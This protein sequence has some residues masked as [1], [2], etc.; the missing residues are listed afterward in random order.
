MRPIFCTSRSLGRRPS[1]IICHDTLGTRPNCRPQSDKR[2]HP[3]LERSLLI[4][5]SLLKRQQLPTLTKLRHEWNPSEFEDLARE[6]WFL[7]P[8]FRFSSGS[9]GP[10]ESGFEVKL[11]ADDPEAVSRFETQMSRILNLYVSRMV[12]KLLPV[13][14]G[15]P[16][17]RRLV[18]S[19]ELEG[20]GLPPFERTMPVRGEQCLLDGLEFEV[21]LFDLRNRQPYRIP[22]R[23][24][25]EYLARWGGVHIYD[26]GFR[27]PSEPG[28]DW[29][30]L[31]SDQSR[32]LAHSRLLPPEL[33][34]GMASRL[35]P[36]TSSMFAVVH[37]DASKEAETSERRGIGRYQCLQ[38]RSSREGFVENEAF[39]QLRDVI[40][41]SLDH[42]ATRL[43]A[44]RMEDASLRHPARSPQ[45]LIGNVLDVLDDHSGD[46]PPTVATRLRTELENTVEAIR[47]QSEWARR[48]SGLLG[49]MAT[50]GVTSIAFDHQFNQQL[51]VLEY[52]ISTLDNPSPPCPTN[53]ATDQIK[54]WIRDVRRTRQMFSPV[55]DEHNRS[56][57]TRFRARDILHSL[58]DN[59]TPLLR[60]ARVDLSGV[61]PD[62]RLPETSYPV[63]MAIFHNLLLNATNAMLDTDVKR[64]SASSFESGA[65]RGIRLC[66]TGIGMDLDEAESLFEPL[67]RRVAI[68]SD[69]RAL[70][71][72]GSGLGLAI[73]RMLATDVKMDVRFMEPPSPFS[74]CFEMSWQEASIGRAASLAR[75]AKRGV[76][77]GN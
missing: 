5:N 19:L 64:I 74:T 45:S 30:N 16:Q 48:Q 38:M 59:L 54:E 62:L 12:G 42:Y 57:T 66:D 44:R 10:Q 67:R 65:R 40:G 52:H 28:T 58:S 50:V 4:N 11:S 70:G 24:A 53:G 47:E 41:M 51:S 33:T 3:P 1:F 6:I 7:Q 18:L 71:Y 60:G 35:L 37:V 43:A 39:E 2:I 63:W 20:M 68:S 15:G 23:R 46:M 26:A 17:D 36:T 55:T 32:R 9:P 61:D 69:R 77:H 29:L 76:P 27:V 49:A 73:V 75:S 56:A 22:V 34:A 8:P 14:G 25:R 72:G 21:R 13:E 31:E